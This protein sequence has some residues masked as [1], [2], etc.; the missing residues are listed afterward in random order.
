MTKLIFT[1]RVLD[2]TLKNGEEG[3][4]VNADTGTVKWAPIKSI[5]LTVMTLIGVVGSAMTFS[6]ETF[7][8]FIII[9]AVTICAGHSV[10]LHRL[11]IHRSFKVNKTVEYIL[12]YLG[13]LVSM[14]GPLGMIRLH[15]MRDWGQRQVSCHDFFAHSAGFWKDAWWQ[16]HC[17]LELNNPPV[18]QLEASLMDDRFYRVLERTWMLQQLP[19]A[20]VLYF[21]GGIPFIIWGVCLRVSVSLIGH[22]FVGYLAHQTQDQVFNIKDTCVQGYNLDRLGIITFGESYHGNHHAFPQSAKLG[23]LK[24]QVDIGWWFVCALQKVGLASNLN[25]PDSLELRKGIEL[26]GSKESVDSLLLKRV[27]TI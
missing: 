7:A 12:V 17:K 3:A 23:F 24:G 4:C 14:A 6:W 5:W 21:I 27:S 11:L 1:E 22:W 13:V 15:D 20:V 18:F 16:L 10:G 8:I 2:N 19:L 26:V 25:T 9:T